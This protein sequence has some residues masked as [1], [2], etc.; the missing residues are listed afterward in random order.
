M[1]IM[2]IYSMVY[3]QDLI[4]TQQG[5]SI[6]C[7]VTKIESEFIHFTYNHSG[8]IRNTLL[9]DTQIKHLE[10]GYF[11]V[12]EVSQ[13]EVFKTLTDRFRFAAHGGF[14]Y[15]LASVADDVPSDFK[16]YV[17]QMKTGYHFGADATYFITESYGL[18]LKYSLF[19]SKNSLDNIYAV[20]PNGQ[21]RYGIMS[22]NLS[23]SFFGPSLV[24]R[25]SNH[26]RSRTFI[27]GLAIGYMSYLDKKVIIDPF[28]VTGSTLGLSF[29]GGYD[30]KLKGNSGIGFQISYISG[31]L[32]EFIIDDGKT[33]ETMKFPKGQFES[34]HRI[35]FSIGYRFVR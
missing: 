5:D 20:G 18:G 33:K 12:S 21:T 17:R 10:Y 26:D 11:E 32:S 24:N 34:L 1:I 2:A 22:D 15:T 7:R 23:I 6:N 28:T 13:E 16:D 29:E 14:S 19:K 3:S 25:S 8:E 31:L 4:V 30:I 35:D 9:R 27:A